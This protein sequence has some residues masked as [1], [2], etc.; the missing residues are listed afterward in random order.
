M[1]GEGVPFTGSTG[2]LLSVGSSVSEENDDQMHNR[3][4]SHL[5][6]VASSAPVIRVVDEDSVTELAQSLVH[7][8]LQSAVTQLQQ[9]QSQ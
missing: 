9:S 1:L 5:S 7:H 8:A 3:T 2:S 4:P 6:G